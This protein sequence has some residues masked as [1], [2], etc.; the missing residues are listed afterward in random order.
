MTRIKLIHCIYETGK[1]RPVLFYYQY[2]LHLVMAGEKMT[3]LSLLV[4]A[5][6]QTVLP[7]DV[8]QPGTQKTPNRSQ[9]HPNYVHAPKAIFA[10]KSELK[11]PYWAGNFPMLP[12]CANLDLLF[13]GSIA[14]EWRRRTK[15]FTWSIV[16]QFSDSECFFMTELNNDGCIIYF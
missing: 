10:P 1:C 16:C 6:P 11:L 4:T 8:F 9:T 2:T 14:T 15:H 3:G 13:T 12:L 5:S 7:W